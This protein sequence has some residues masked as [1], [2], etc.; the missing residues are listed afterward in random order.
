MSG[1]KLLRHRMSDVTRWPRVRDLLE[2][3]M[4]LPSEER[5]RFLERECGDAELRIEV[6]ELLAQD[7]RTSGLEPPPSSSEGRRI[8]AFVLRREIGT[9]GMGKVYLAERVDGAFRQRVAIKVIKRGMDTDE[10]LRRFKIE[11]QVLADLEHPDHAR[12]YDRR[13]TD[14]RLPYLSLE[15]VDGVVIDPCCAH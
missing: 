10:I 6:E 11:R 14:D 1:D 3:A 2:R 12:P 5:E 13:A 7:A 8:G 4:D 9:G 15:V